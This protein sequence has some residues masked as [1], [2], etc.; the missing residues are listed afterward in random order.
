MSRWLFNIPSDGDSTA[1][2]GQIAPVFSH[3]QVKTCFVMFRHRLLCLLLPVASCSAIRNQGKE[4]DYNFFA[5]SLEAFIYIDVFPL[6]QAQVSQPF[7]TGEMLQC[8]NIFM[9]LCCFSPVCPYLFCTGH[10][11]SADSASDVASP[12]LHKREGS[13][14]L[15]Y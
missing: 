9:A 1:I 6:E 15:T 7:L 4:P 2:C 5:P 13:L 12:V 14:P 3:P 8:F 10:P 11:R